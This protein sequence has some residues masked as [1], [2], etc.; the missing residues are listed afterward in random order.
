MPLQEGGLGV[1]SLKDICEAFSYKLWF[2]FRDQNSLWADCIQVKYCRNVYPGDARHK[3]TD[4]LIWKRMLH[5][6]T[7]AQLPCYWKL[8][9]G[10]CYFWRD[11][12]SD[13]GLLKDQ[14]IQP[15]N[16]LDL[17]RDIG[18][19]NSWDWDKLSG[20]LPLPSA[21]KLYLIPFNSEAP[22][23]LLWKLTPDGMFSTKYAWELVR[24]KFR[25][26]KVLSLCWRSRLSTTMSIFWWKILHNWLPV[27]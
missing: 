26:N 2:R 27:E 11:H 1:R 5:S 15:I 17:V 6:S 24:K 18:A 7:E 10:P 13:L 19:N 21:A 9:Q 4:S 3:N 22:A 12:W 16:N 20:N 8:G 14:A 25:F 23:Q